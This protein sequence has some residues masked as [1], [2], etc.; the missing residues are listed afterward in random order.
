VNITDV[1]QLTPGQFGV[2]HGS[3]LTG[4]LIR[5]AT[6]SWAGH[7]FIY[8]GGGMLI[9][10]NPP[11]ADI[12]PW[13]KYDDAI[14]TY[15]MPITTAQSTAA[16]ARAH[17]LVG[18]PYDYAA[19]VGFALEVLNLAKGTQLDP[20]FKSDKWRVC[21]ALV[22]DCLHYSGIPLDWSAIKLVPGQDPNLVSP[23]MLLD[24]AT[25]VGWV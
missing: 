14:W 11:Q 18:T 25:V 5:H 17:A 19:Y 2:S 8:V 20:V 4:E 10:G 21:S 7:A 13:N 22:D 6:E 15:R 16:V 24:L 9:E 12:A 3:G 23:A 1:S